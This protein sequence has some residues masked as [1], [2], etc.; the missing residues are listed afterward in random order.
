MSS[1]LN[2]CFN[3]CC[4]SCLKRESDCVK[5]TFQKIPDKTDIMIVAES[6][7]IEDVF[8]PGT[9][10]KRIKRVFDGKHF[11][12]NERVYFTC[13]E[14][15][16][17]PGEV[18]PKRLE[19]CLN[20]L[21]E[22]I[23]LIKPKF[24]LGMGN[25]VLKCLTGHSGITNHNGQIYDTSFGKVICT[26]KPSAVDYNPK[27]AAIFNSDIE[28]VINLC[29]NI[30]SNLHPIVHL[31]LTKKD[32]IEFLD[33]MASLPEENKIALDLETTTYDYWRPETHVMCMGICGDGI[34]TYSIPLYHPQSPFRTSENFIMDKLSLY[35]KNRT[36]IG[37]NWK[38]DLKWMRFKYHKEV[39]FKPD[40]ML[41]SY[42][43]DEN[44]PH[45]LKYQADQY[46]K[47]G[48]YDKAVTWPV[49]FDPVKDDI[50]KKV[51]E[52]LAMDLHSLLKY[53]ALD[54][55]YSW[56][57]Y[58]VE[59]VKLLKDI[60]SARIYKHLLEPANLM[61]S[62]IEGFGM[63]IDPDRLAKATIECQKKTNELLEKLNSY[64]P[65]GWCERNLGPKQYKQGFNW[66]S[67]KQLGCLFYQDDG[68]H[69]SIINKTKTGQPST[70]EATIKE[71]NFEVNHP[72]LQDLLDYREQTVFMT[73][74]LRPWA[75]KIDCNSRLHPNF[76]LHGTVTGR[77]SGEDGVHQVPRDK[78]IRSLI[79]APPGW[80][81]FEID[82]SQIEL[83]VVSM[84]AK[85][86]TMLRV[87]LQGGDIHTETAMA[88]TGKIAAD[89]T[90]AERKNAKPVNFGFVY[91]M[92]WKKFGKYAFE[93]Y[94]VRFTDEEAKMYRERYF[95]KYS[96]LPI[97]HEEVR[98][99]VRRLGYV[100]SP[101]GRKRR[102]P[103]I[104]SNDKGMQAAAEREGINSPVQSMGSDVVLAA[105][106]DLVFNKIMPIDPNFET[107]R[108]VGMVH[109]AQYLEIRND[110]FD[111]W[112]PIIKENFDNSKERLKKWFGFDLPVAIPGDMK[113]G[114]YW[115]EAE[116]WKIGE[117]YPHQMR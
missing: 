66:N 89:I 102:L 8:T 68:L 4:E 36:W 105:Y 64:I 70:D 50:E 61:F 111:F 12:W 90:K 17:I 96:R 104:Y 44:I 58:P 65:E 106:I 26:V 2:N 22:E 13:I 73:R 109:D 48:H 57:V 76:K 5:H 72:V 20:L 3:R 43:N 113:I 81:F 31:V 15:C 97:W 116:D 56:N 25:T 55:F 53:N 11:N 34:N 38:Y 91:G 101:I 10:I 1:T 14:K 33:H 29:D 86:P 95:K 45:G 87:Y 46:F 30:T 82:G 94:S 83:R 21:M 67:T 23:K 16:M 112:A 6:V 63:W 27:L 103:H 18:T 41:M 9:S 60:K 84:I 49:E 52:Y 69:F 93:K 78:F 79:G 92:G 77:L 117:P 74:Y 59:R 115:G 75:C 35:F 100:E 28:T 85:E 24:I 71:L 110:K 40:N 7:D 51:K 19:S 37:N 108:P 62:Y 107:I 80:T 88:L 32:W 98:R 47:A 99:I 39:N 42:A 54:A 114:N